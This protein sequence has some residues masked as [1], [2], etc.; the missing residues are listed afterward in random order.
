MA[1]VSPVVYK[2]ALRDSAR[3]G[4]T[5]GR[6]A[7][8][9]APGS[10]DGTPV[11]AMLLDHQIHSAVDLEQPARLVYE[12]EKL[13]AW[14]LEGWSRGRPAPAALFIGGGGYTFLRYV[15]RVYP[16]SKADVAE[17][18]PAVTETA[19]REFLPASTA[20]RSFAGD[21]RLVLRDLPAG[22]R[23]DLIFGDA[24]H[25]ISVPYHLTTVEFARLIRER[26]GQEGLYITHVVMTSGRLLDWAQ[27]P[28]P[29][30]EMRVTPSPW[31]GPPEPYVLT[32]DHAP[33]DNLLWQGIAQWRRAQGSRS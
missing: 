30:P 13:Y 33:V 6:L 8:A 29:G 26:L 3:T 5:V 24:Y 11:K 18:D 4:G 32:D 20:I 22:E 17:M 28:A 19:R 25:G 27:W 1:A 2:L 12:Y 10:M 9:G 31:A 21:G 23:Y 14:V 15:D 7:A 16:G